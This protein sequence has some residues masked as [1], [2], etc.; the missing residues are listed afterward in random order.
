MSYNIRSST[1]ADEAGIHDVYRAAAAQGGGLLRR[2]DEITHD[3]VWNNLK[4]SLETGITLVAEADGGRI[5]GEIHG[6]PSPTRQLGHCLTNLTL[7]V[8]PSAQGRGVGQALFT[9][10]IEVANL[11]PRLRIIELYCR[12]DN[13]RAIDLYQKMGFVFEGRLKGRVWQGEGKPYL[14]DLLMALYLSTDV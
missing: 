3:Y 9:R 14:D 12:E 1:V 8:D 4:H 13:K 10:L 6:W 7:A 5:L 2:E 11:D